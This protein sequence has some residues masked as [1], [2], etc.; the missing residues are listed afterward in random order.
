MASLV[1]GFIGYAKCILTD[2][3]IDEY[4]PA[5]HC[6]QSSI[7]NLF[8][9]IRMMG[10]DR[11]DLY[12]NGIMQQNIK[13]NIKMQ[14]EYTASKAY[15]GNMRMESTNA[16]EDTDNKF[17]MA[18]LCKKIKEKK[19]YVNMTLSNVAL[20]NI[21]ST[22]TSVMPNGEH[23]VETVQ[24]IICYPKLGDFNLPLDL[25][26]QKYMASDEVFIKMLL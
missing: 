16:N 15:G 1:F 21:V 12:G 19:M 9:N 2:K 3:S 14:K 7:E 17:D 5:L 18:S 4:V 24:G 26:Y 22:S 11:T 8:S 20:R 25:N 6:N 10:K 13:E 23:L